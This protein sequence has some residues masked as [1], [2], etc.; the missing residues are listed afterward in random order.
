[1]VLA[2]FAYAPWRHY[3]SLPA[4]IITWGAPA[5]AAWHLALIIMYRPKI[6]YIAYALLNLALYLIFGFYCLFWVTGDSI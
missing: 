3:D 1:M 2:T 4:Y 5:T 6:L